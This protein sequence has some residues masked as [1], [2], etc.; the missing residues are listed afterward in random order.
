MIE[1]LV[2]FFQG[3]SYCRGCGC[4]QRVFEDPRISQLHARIWQRDWRLGVEDLSTNGCFVNGQKL[5]KGNSTHLVD[6]D[7]VSLVVTPREGGGRWFHPDP[8]MNDVFVAYRVVIPKTWCA[9]PETHEE[10]PATTIDSPPDED[11]G[12]AQPEEF[13]KPNPCSRGGHAKAVEQDPIA[14]FFAQKEKA[15]TKSCFE[16]DFSLGEVLGEGGFAK[17]CNGIHKQSQK[18]VAVK[19]IDKIRWRFKHGGGS[20]NGLRQGTCGLRQTQLE[21]EFELHSKL[22]HPNIVR[23]VAS[24]DFPQ[25]ECS[26]LAFLKTYLHRFYGK[27]DGPKYIHIVMEKVNRVCFC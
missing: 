25:I 13:V 1:R 23:Y 21:E 15:G 7:I 10:L 6:G 3:C 17:V 24:R 12:D 11:V 9:P 14:L 22:F 27:Y 4:A 2:P 16:D 5:G 20:T 18:E 26:F 8:T 19:V